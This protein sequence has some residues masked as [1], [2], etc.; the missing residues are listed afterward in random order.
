MSWL[1]DM[2]ATDPACPGPNNDAWAAAR[3]LRGTSRRL[4]PEAGTAIREWADAEAAVPERRH[5][6]QGGDL[7]LPSRTLTIDEAYS[8]L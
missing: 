1:N 2:E 4:P 5:I 6:G 3:H 7:C 8:V